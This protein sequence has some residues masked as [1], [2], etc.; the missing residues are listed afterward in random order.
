MSPRGRGLGRGFVGRG[1]GGGDGGIYRLRDGSCRGKSTLSGNR[2]RVSPD[3]IKVASTLT[4]PLFKIA[5]KVLLAG[6]QRLLDRSVEQ[7][8]LDL[9]QIQAEKHPRQLAKHRDQLNEDIIDVEAEVIADEMQNNL[10]TSD[11]TRISTNENE[12]DTGVIR[13]KDRDHHL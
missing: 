2:S 5:G 9:D 11:K 10:P 12:A 7:S 6:V 4:F 8:F 1:R 3:A 13:D